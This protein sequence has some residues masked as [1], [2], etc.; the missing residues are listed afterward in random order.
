MYYDFPLQ[1]GIYWAALKS[2]TRVENLPYACA[3]VVIFPFIEKLNA[4]TILSNYYMS[5]FKVK[6]M[7]N[8]KQ[9]AEYL[10]V[11]WMCVIA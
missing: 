6:Q 9:Y 8:K 11:L 5:R 3:C 2:C 4:F 7:K 10:S 1:A